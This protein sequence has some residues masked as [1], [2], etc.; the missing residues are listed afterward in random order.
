M[1]SIS[2]IF[3]FNIKSSLQSER[4]TLVNK[5]SMSFVHAC[6]ISVQI[7][8]LIPKKLTFEI[9]SM[10]TNLEHSCVKVMRR[11]QLLRRSPQRSALH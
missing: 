4:N 6:T 7:N 1:S 9:G 8:N 11:A 10:N 3:D 5:N 2:Y